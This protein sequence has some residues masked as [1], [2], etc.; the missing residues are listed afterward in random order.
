MVAMIE[1]LAIVAGRRVT[2][3]RETGGARSIEVD[4]DCVARVSVDELARGDVNERAA[5]AAF[6]E[7]VASL[8]EVG[9]PRLPAVGDAM[10]DDE[11]RLAHA[12]QVLRQEGNISQAARKLRIGRATLRRWARRW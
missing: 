2:V 11:I 4:G 8:E 12:K 7:I 5:A 6:A 1:K 10:T 9:G 3:I